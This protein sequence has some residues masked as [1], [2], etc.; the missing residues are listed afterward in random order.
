MPKLT[1][2][3]IRS[4]Q[5][6][7]GKLEVQEFDDELPGFGVRKFASCKASLFVKYSVGSQQRRKTL[8]P[9]LAGT[10]PTIRKEAA[11][12]LAQAR[13]GKDVVGE[14]R[15]AQQEA[16]KAKKLGELVG[17]YLELRE[18]GNEFW[19]PMRPKSHVETTRYL[20]RSWQPL[21]DKPV[22]EITRQMVRDRRNEI[23]SES[24]AVSA[25]RAL[26]ALSGLCG[27]AIE[28]EYIS[29]TNPVSDIKPLHENGRERVLSEEELVEI[30]LAAGDDEFGRIVKLLM[31]T[32]QRRTEIGN[33]EWAEVRLQQAMIDLPSSRT[34]NKKRHL[35]PLSEPALALLG[36][37]PTGGKFVFG[38]FHW[39]RGKIDLVSLT[40][41]FLRHVSQV[42]RRRDF[43]CHTKC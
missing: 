34:K 37:S 17:P 36:I 31:L 9:W 29:G 33:L 42:F 6:P 35:V 5:V 7:E 8:G 39:N 23:V 3:F 25:N 38:V 26:A 40:K 28:Q 21:H 16:A 20:Q 43:L 2:Q 30:W 4:L 11:V 10:L 32:G 12:V 1:N 24:G 41:R 18:M 15:K 14:A 22:N 27:W 13:L 19:K